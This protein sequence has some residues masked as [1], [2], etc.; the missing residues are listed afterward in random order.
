MSSGSCDDGRQR[1]APVAPGPCG[2]LDCRGV[3]SGCRRSHPH[4][5]RT[6]HRKSRAGRSAEPAG[7]AGNPPSGSDALAPCPLRSGRDGPLRGKLVPGGGRPSCRLGPSSLHRC[8]FAT[9]QLPEPACTAESRGA[10]C[11]AVRWLAR[12]GPLGPGKLPYQVEGWQKVR[13][14][15]WEGW[16]RLSDLLF[17]DGYDR[18]VLPA[19]RSAVRTARANSP[20][21]W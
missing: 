9:D 5:R 7:G 12:G 6:L 4:G 8:G 17:I 16:V 1:S 2:P 11:L 3:G 19:I 18:A 13:Q 15:G 20:C 10:A 14:G 21:R